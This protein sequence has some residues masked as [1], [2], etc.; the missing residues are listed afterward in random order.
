MLNEI[1][2]IDTL[3]HDEIV[4]LACQQADAGLPLEHGFA[5]STTQAATYERSYHER[6]R[7]LRA[8]V[9]V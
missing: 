3:T 7:E 5:P 8:E 4:H 6:A 1:R 9:E 2:S